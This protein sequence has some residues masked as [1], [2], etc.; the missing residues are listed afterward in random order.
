M[1]EVT[2]RKADPSDN[3]TES[4]LAEC[5]RLLAG[6][7]GPRRSALLGHLRDEAE[8]SSR[9]LFA[10]ELVGLVRRGR[11]GWRRA[12]SALA[13]LGVEGPTALGHELLGRRSAV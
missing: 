7:D 3:D 2:A 1:P 8:P 6:P 4:M 12:A 9:R 13:E 11:L 10:R 5:L